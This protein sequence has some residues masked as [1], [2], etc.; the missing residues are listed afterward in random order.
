MRLV[1]P[2]G[3][4]SFN[5]NEHAKPSIT[6]QNST[7]VDLSYQQTVPMNISD[8]IPVPNHQTDVQDVLKTPSSLKVPDNRKYAQSGHSVSIGPMPSEQGLISDY[9]MQQ[10]RQAEFMTGMNLNGPISTIFYLYAKATDN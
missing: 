7:R 2:E 1:D 6:P 4:Q 9:E 5:W 10:Q 8:E 3:T